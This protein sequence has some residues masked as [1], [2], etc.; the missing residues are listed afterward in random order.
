MCKYSKSKRLIDTV[1]SFYNIEYFS[2]LKRVAGHSGVFY[3]WGRKRSGAQAIELANKFATSYVLLED[4]FIRSVGLGVDGSPSFSIVEDDSGIYYDSTQSS[5]LEILLNTFDFSGAETLMKTA[6]M[7][8]TLIKKHHISKYNHAP[9]IDA[10]YF[11]ENRRRVLIV[12]QTSGD[13]SLKY[14]QAD[15]FTTDEMIDVAVAENPDAEVYIKVHPDVLCGKKVSD[16]DI[17][18]VRNRCIVLDENVNPISLLESF[19]KIYTK[20]SQM[21][22]EALLLGKQCACFGVPFY[23]GW[24]ITDDRVECKRR[25]RKLKVEEVFAAAYILY[26]RYFNPY[27][28]EPCDIVDAVKEIVEQKKITKPMDTKGYY[29]GF[30]RWKHGFVR[31]FFKEIKYE[32]QIF[33]NPLFRKRH[34]KKALKKGLNSKSRIYI[35]GRKSFNAVRQYAAENK[36]PLYYVEDGFVRSVGLGSDL[37]QPYSLVVDS[38]GIYFDQTESSDLEEILNHYDFTADLKL[39]ER[40]NAVKRV[41]LEKK[42]S[43]YNYFAQSKLHIPSLKHI[44]V[45]PGQVEDDASVRLGASGMSNLDLIKRVRKKAPESYIIYKPHPDVVVG[46]RIGHVEREDILKLCDLVVTD[47]GLDSVLIHADAVHTMTSLVGFEALMRGIEVH[48]YGMPFYAGW[49]LT[50]DEVRCERRHRR[51]SLDEL[52][53][54]TLLLYPRYLDPKT[55]ELCTIEVL[56]EALEFEQKKHATT[57]RYQVFIKLRNFI[58]RKIQVLSSLLKG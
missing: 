13:A 2:L 47:V 56:L 15:R 14:G 44:I 58:I 19:D 51:V 43:K 23:A 48:T 50:Q 35:W 4:G 20:T 28:N 24:G 42:L 31:P 17:E 30:S 25:K 33:I 5:R 54:G 22:F 45:V 32:N 34:L 36:I 46:N 38:K 21:G 57:K 39:L 16:I 55:K 6:R 26:A 7:A 11:P 41:I 1:S 52:I 53:A 29:F 9:D 37:T 40:A 18:T 27:K 10:S 12:A 8:I 3:G 49:G